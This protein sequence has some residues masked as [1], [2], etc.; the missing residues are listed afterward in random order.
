MIFRFVLFPPP[1]RLRSPIIYATETGTRSRLRGKAYHCRRARL[2]CR[3]F[4]LV[5]RRAC[6][7]SLRSPLIRTREPLST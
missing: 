3:V 7:I 6:Q 5:Y 4:L 1:H 2:R